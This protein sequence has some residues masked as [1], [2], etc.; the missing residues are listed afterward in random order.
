MLLNAL[1]GKTLTIY[2]DGKNIR[3]WLYVGDN[4]EALKLV[5]ERGKV[6]ETYNIGGCC[7]KTNIEVVMSICTILDQLCPDSPQIPHK[8]LITFVKDRPGHDRRYAVDISKIEKELGWRPKETFE[9]GLKKTIQWYID[10]PKWIESV[11]TGAYRNWIE[12]NYEK[13]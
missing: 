8:S 1:E 6:G 4:N 10:N 3:D 11:I 12:Q 9:T 7:E 13:R 2:G 5:V